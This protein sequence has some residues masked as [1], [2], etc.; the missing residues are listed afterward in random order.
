MQILQHVPKVIFRLAFDIFKDLSAYRS[1]RMLLYKIFVGVSCKWAFD[2]I[3][4]SYA[5]SESNYVGV[6][7]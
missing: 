1:E 3:M 7:R 6:P 4:T 2:I 5:T